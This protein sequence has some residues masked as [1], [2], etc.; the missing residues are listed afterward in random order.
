MKIFKV[1]AY[2]SFGDSVDTVKVT[3]KNDVEARQKAI[4]L[5]VPKMHKRY[6]E[7]KKRDARAKDLASD[8]S[9]YTFTAAD[10]AYCSVEYVGNLDG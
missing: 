6:Q 9:V 5:I 10:V 1:T 7:M 8:L 3:A 2:D 4:K